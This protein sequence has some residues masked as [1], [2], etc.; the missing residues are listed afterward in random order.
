[1]AAT[2]QYREVREVEVFPPAIFVGI[3]VDFK[4]AAG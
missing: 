1:M 4:V 2:A 3:V